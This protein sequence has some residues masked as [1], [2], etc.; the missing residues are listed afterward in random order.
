MAGNREL[1]F[2]SYRSGSPTVSTKTCTDFDVMA[3][4]DG[5]CQDGSGTFFKFTP[6]ASACLTRSMAVSWEIALREIEGKRD[7]KK[8]R[9]EKGEGR[10]EKGGG[11][12]G[13]KWRRTSAAFLRKAPWLRGRSHSIQD[14]HNP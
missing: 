13:E 8:T 3:S 4:K 11:S 2:A 12:A 9:R 6:S 5:G 14:T 7:R 10:R 1:S